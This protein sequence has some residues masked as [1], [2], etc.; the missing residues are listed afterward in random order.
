MSA[1]DIFFAKIKSIMKKS[2]FL[3]FASFSFVAVNAQIKNDRGTFTKP[4]KDDIIAEINFSPSIG[5]NNPSI[6][7]LPNVFDGIIGVKA[8]K[9]ISDKKA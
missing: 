4:K 9:F 5:G 3:L 7:S 2:L 8:R 1:F 6:F